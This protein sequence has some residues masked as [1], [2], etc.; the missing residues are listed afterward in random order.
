MECLWVNKNV[1]VPFV[2]FALVYVLFECWKFNVIDHI[3]VAAPS[4]VRGFDVTS[5]EVEKNGN[6]NHVCKLSSFFFI[7]FRRR[8]RRHRIPYGIFLYA[9]SPHSLCSLL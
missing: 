7:C 9:I 2:I 5:Q 8:R 6:T 1:Y 3:A 4:R